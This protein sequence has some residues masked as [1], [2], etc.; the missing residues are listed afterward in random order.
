M[1]GA[2]GRARHIVG[3]FGPAHQSSL[4]GP[5]PRQPN[6]S[7]HQVS[8][9]YW[10]VQLDSS[11]IPARIDPPVQWASTRALVGQPAIV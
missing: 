1:P 2:L 4:L 7:Q 6:S 8:V 3:L 9:A 5:F 11:L 10:S